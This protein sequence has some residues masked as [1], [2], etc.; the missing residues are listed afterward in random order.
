MPATTWSAKR[1]RQYAHIRQSLLS[2]GRSGKVSEEIAA[3]TVNKVRA[4]E[5]ES[6]T[7]SPSSLNEISPGRR[8]GLRSH[9]GP[10]G[11]T[12][13]QFRNEDRKRGIKGRSKIN[14]S[15]LESALT[16]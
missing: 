12:V 13:L 3:R 4:Q 7:S 5:G 9:S 14:K 16:T 11:R 15:Q 10:S 2:G 1:Q 6:V 8:G